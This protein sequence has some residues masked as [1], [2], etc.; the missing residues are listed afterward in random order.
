M[1]P[2]NPRIPAKNSGTRIIFAS[3]AGLYVLICLCLGISIFV[4]REQIP[5]VRD[6]FPTA[7]ST[8]TATLASPRPATGDMVFQDDFSDNKNDW[9]VDTTPPTHL[10]ISNGK[11]N[12]HV[13]KENSRGYI[14]CRLCPVLKSPYYLQADFLTNQVTKEFYG[15]AFSSSDSYDT[16]YLFEIAP[17]SGLFCFYKYKNQH[18]NLY[19]SRKTDLVKPYPNANMLGIRFDHDLMTLYINQTVVDTFSDTGNSMGSGKFWPYVDSN[20]FTLML[21]NVYSYGAK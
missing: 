13:E 21:D 18:W 19:I 12:I 16:F 1:E 10:E 7:T 20:K 5:G 9:S 11:L 14:R 17:D 4:L 8:P 3:M 15:L 6:Y 2:T